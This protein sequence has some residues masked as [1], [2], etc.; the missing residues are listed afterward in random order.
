MR[1]NRDWGGVGVWGWGGWGAAAGVGRGA[2]G[3]AVGAGPPFSPAPNPP[4]ATHLLLRLELRLPRLQHP[5]APG[6]DDHAA[7]GG[8]HARQLVHKLAAGPGGRGGR[9]QRGWGGEAV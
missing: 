9:R 8:A 2:V 4:P 3:V 1:S 7:A 5:V 6:D